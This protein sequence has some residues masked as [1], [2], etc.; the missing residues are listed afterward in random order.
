MGIGRE[1]KLSFL[2]FG[3]FVTLV[4]VAMMANWDSTEVVFV[5]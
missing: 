1:N 5:G 3:C 4:D 2:F